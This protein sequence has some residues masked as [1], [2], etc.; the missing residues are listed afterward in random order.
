MPDETKKSGTS[1]G[2]LR[3]SPGRERSAPDE[4]VFREAVTSALIEQMRRMGAAA[5]DQSRDNETFVKLAPQ[6]RAQLLTDALARYQNHTPFAIGQL[7]KWKQGFRTRNW[8]GDGDP[9]IVCEVLPQPFFDETPDSTSPYYREPLDLRL[10]VIGVD[11][12]FVTY[13]FDA[14]RFEP[15]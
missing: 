15:F 14:R 8:P 1:L 7:V 2:W 5:A 13:W 6:Q 9:A 4:T 11:G 10:G 3:A 12:H